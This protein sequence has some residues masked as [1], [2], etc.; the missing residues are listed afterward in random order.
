MDLTE[1]Q[2]FGP[3]GAAEVLRLHAGPLSMHFDREWGFLRKISLGGQVLVRAVYGAVR[4]DSWV[5]VK[6]SLDQIELRRE[7]G[8]FEL[9]FRAV[10]RQPDAGIDFTWQGR[11]T[12]SAEG[13]VRYEF[14]GEAGC[15]LRSNRI[16]LC[17][18]HPLELAGGPLT[19]EQADG[20]SIKTA[21][22]E[23]IS[24]HQVQFGIRSLT[25]GAA[26]G[27]LLRLE[28]EGD[29][30][31]MEDE[32]N[33]SDAGFKTYGTPLSA[34]IPR[35]LKSGDRVE[36]SVTLR[37]LGKPAA[38]LPVDPGP[39]TLEIGRA[40][41]PLPSVG[42]RWAPD[43][44]PL[45]PAEWERLAALG[46]GH[47]LIDC[48]VT[49]NDWRHALPPALDACERLGTRPLLML[50]F[51][52]NYQPSLFE[53]VGDLASWGDRLLGVLVR[54]PQETSPGGV[55]LGLVRD[56]FARIGCRAPI[57]AAPASV[58]AE[59]NRHRPP[60]EW[61]V[62]VPICPQV[63]TFDNE[64]L[65]DNVHTQPVMLR[66]AA[67]FTSRPIFVAPIALKRRRQPDSRQ[68]TLFCAAWTLGS[69]SRLLPLGTPRTGDAAGTVA[70]L[71]Y[72]EHAGP[73]G[74]L[75][76]PT[77]D[78]FAA[79]AGGAAVSEVRASRP[80]EV[81]A[82]LLHIPGDPAH[83][84]LANL[85]PQEVE[86]EIPGGDTVELGPHAFAALELE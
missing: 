37:L 40:E 80:R 27:C 10:C 49:L 84:L 7:Q 86:V 59:I 24:P 70:A 15:D 63:H 41:V 25:H 79:L 12:G 39:V 46:L 58:F 32:R 77:E 26:E 2:I 72:H 11:I 1:E 17:T 42:T 13:E 55:T 62:S 22:P 14:S 35:R 8:G 21:F 76:T 64:S 74:I 30:F 20:G 56:A 51:S 34:G 82:L 68:S 61:S 65:L 31:E 48:D 57:A 36:Q 43:A 75:G 28:F 54:N 5:T 67:Q 53:L 69:L 81:A 85:T 23:L 47:L 52:P 3:G 16:G 29:I 18:L 50:T 83:L 66:S 6:P 44:P 71:T 60:P 73:M 78:V 33:W 38:A 45:T 4:T 19:V 9:T